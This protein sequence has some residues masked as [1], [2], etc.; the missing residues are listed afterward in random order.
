MFINIFVYRYSLYVHWT[1]TIEMWEAR[2]LSRSVRASIITHSSYANLLVSFTSTEEEHLDHRIVW[3][4]GFHYVLPIIFSAAQLA[5]SSYVPA[6]GKTAMLIDSA[7]VIINIASTGVTTWRTTLL[8][9]LA[10]DLA[11]SNARIVKAEELARDIL[12]AVPVPRLVPDDSSEVIE[13]GRTTSMAASGRAIGSPK[14]S[15][16]KAST[17]QLNPEHPVSPQSG[18]S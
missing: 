5:M 13:S 3:S 6:S 8:N 4:L 10:K 15:I 12:K 16:P 2:R 11:A 14:D 9:D 1:H 18:S 17:P 7:K